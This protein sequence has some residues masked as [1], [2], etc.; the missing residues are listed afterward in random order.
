MKA[1]VVALAALSPVS[2]AESLCVNYE[3]MKVTGFYLGEN[4]NENENN[5]NNN[6]NMWGAVSD[7]GRGE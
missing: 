5:N 6:N 2:L 3:D 7:S 1:L 4:E